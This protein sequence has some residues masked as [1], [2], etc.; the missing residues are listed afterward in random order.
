MAL[1]AAVVGCGS[2]ATGAHLPNLQQNPL[3]D[4]VCTCDTNPEAAQRAADRFGAKRFCTDWHDVVAADDIDLIV[5]ATHTN[6]RGELICEACCNGKPVYSEKPLATSRREMMEIFQVSHETDVPVC[7]GHNR[8]S[9]PGVI[10]FKRLIDKARAEGTDRTAVIDRSA[11]KKT[12]MQEETEM[13]LLLRVNDDVRTWKE[14]VFSDREGVFH[15]EMVHFIDLALWLI[16]EVPVEVYAMGSARGNFTQLIRFRNG[17]LATLV[18]SMVGNFDYPKELLEAY[19]RNC[20]IVCDHHLEVRQ[21]GLD[22]EPFRITFPLTRGRKLT[23]ADGIEAFYEATEKFQQLK[24]QGE[25]DSLDC[26]SP[27]KG[28]FD[29]LARFGRHLLGEGEN[30]CPVDDAIVVTAIGLKLLESVR[31]GQ[32]VKV[33]SEDT[34]LIYAERG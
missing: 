18:H 25:A 5:L 13:Q 30:P 20:T 28:H 21:R 1:R 14:W 29:H 31:L 9:S 34:N 22:T 4:L 33:G 3:F 11:S 19:L 32:P 6:L 7:V 24:A 26:V 10:E 12:L 8:R 16:D 2:L 17:A 15:G 27:N 23:D